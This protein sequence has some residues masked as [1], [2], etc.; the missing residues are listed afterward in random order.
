MANSSIDGRWP[1]VSRLDEVQSF[2]EHLAS[3]DLGNCTIRGSA[4]VGKTRLAEE[5]LAEAAAQG[6]AC[7][8]VIATAATR[9]I[10]LG[11]I[12]H[13]L[14]AAI[15]SDPGG[16]FHP[17]V[18]HLRAQRKKA[19]ASVW[20]VDDLHLLDATSA[21]LIG[22]LVDAREI[23]LLATIRSGEPLSEAVGSLDRGDR[24]HRIDIEPWTAEEVETVLQTVLGG[25]V[26]RGTALLLH[27]ASQG[28]AL[29]LREL[30][31]GSLHS[32]VL[33][34][35]GGVWRCTGPVSGTRRL[36][37]MLQGRI[38]SVSPQG[39]TALEALAVCG[40]VGAA[41]PPPTVLDELERAGLTRVETDGRRATLALAH[42]LYGELLRKQVSSVFR[43][44]LL[45]DRVAW[46]ERTGRRRRGDP[47]LAAQWS[48][49]A[50]GTA[51]PDFLTR[52][53]AM[54][55][56]AEDYESVVRIAQ[57][58]CRLQ[59]G[60]EPRLVLG[61]ALFKL[62]RF[63]D[64]EQAL[65]DAASVAQGDEEV[66]HA[67]ILRTHTLAWGA[68]RLDEALTSNKAARLR[69]TSTEAEEELRVDEAS[70]RAFLGDYGRTLRILND[71]E[72]MHNARARVM[73]AIPVVY[74]LSEA[75][76]NQEALRLANEAYQ[77][78]LAAKSIIAVADPR[79]QLVSKLHALA[80]A[81]RLTE[82][83]TLGEETYALASADHSLFCQVWIAV[84]LGKVEYFAGRLP[85]AV[86][87]F[88]TAAALAS[89]ARFKG[90]QWLSVSGLAQV[91][92]ALGNR[93]K[94]AA[95]WKQVCDLGPAGYTRPD[96]ATLPAWEMALNGR[97]SEA[98]AGFM[99]QAE[100]ARALG[101]LAQES[102]LLMDV[103]RLGGARR[104]RRRLEE[105][106][107]V[108]DSPVPTARAACAAALDQQEPA[109]LLAVA[110]RWDAM[111]FALFAA[112]SY[113]AAAA[114]QRRIGHTRAAVSAGRK[115]SA[116]YAQCGGA[117]VFGIGL[118]DMPALLTMRE[119]EMA[120]FIGRGM[121]NQEIADSLSIS[122]RTVGNHL[123][124]IYQKVGA[125]NRRELARI[126]NDGLLPQE[127]QP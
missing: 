30:V 41:E 66:L 73:G 11:A 27:Q 42:P 115:A 79:M 100:R 32:G 46:L 44:Q 81:G 101:S 28:N 89:D 97:L 96:V 114:A 45:T 14:S 93:A 107:R 40:S 16:L 51:D 22:Q 54:A 70:V 34:G 71:L 87:W 110:E 58:L 102:E 37:E 69:L 2:R 77:E 5:C 86:E 55:R 127:D 3:A 4:G 38:E 65:A 59:P 17:A 91:T 39:R 120:G 113:H 1:L 64:A 20:L 75:G 13:L 124:R 90:A 24:T 85:R 108:C 60:S 56:G 116:L 121:S 26:E 7:S 125:K 68:L 109:P 23:Y 95:L 35:D 98:C 104:V 62:G 88:T 122:V 63:D 84:G 19:H 111:G 53:L 31:S 72:H 119:H 76:R 112:E 29:F 48:L 36:T 103:A 21:V 12:T 8:R 18:Q 117:H 47:L 52:A 78:H 83:R 118:A 99:E 25:P 50:T 67:T 6:Y 106:A 61:D 15:V 82:A 43:K 105:L 9:T 123:Y 57:A 33:V 80:Q 94:V 10:P 49:D 92:A 74:A 126:V